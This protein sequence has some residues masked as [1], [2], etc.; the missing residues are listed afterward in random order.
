METLMPGTRVRVKSSGRTGTIAYA[1]MAPPDYSK[2]EVYS[3]RL[4]HTLR[5]H[6]NGTIIKAEDIEVI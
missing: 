6:Y 1:R 4:D 5:A 3:V 2:P